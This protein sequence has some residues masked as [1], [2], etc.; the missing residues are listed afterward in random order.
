MDGG[1][2]VVSHS[3]D[4]S[5]YHRFKIK[6]MSLRKEHIHYSTYLWL[7]EFDHPYKLLL[8]QKS[9]FYE[10]VSKTGSL[11]AAALTG[12]AREVNYFSNKS[13]FFGAKY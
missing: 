2:A 10:L 5:L 4:C 1:T 7:Q 13:N 6:T 11:A 12:I 9:Y 8:N 3:I